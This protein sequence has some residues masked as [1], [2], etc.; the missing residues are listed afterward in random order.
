MLVCQNLKIYATILANDTS[1]CREVNIKDQGS[2]LLNVTTACD[3]QYSSGR[4]R[5]KINAPILSN[6]SWS[7][8]FSMVTHLARNAWPD[9]LNVAILRYAAAAAL[10]LSA[11]S[12]K[13]DRL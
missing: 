7:V 1:C 11:S 12:S 5:K 2:D 13:A 4:I 8:I 6:D 10:R 3:S 9:L